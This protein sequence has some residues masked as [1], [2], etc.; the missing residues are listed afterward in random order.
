MWTAASLGIDPR[1]FAQDVDRTETNPVHGRQHVD[2]RQVDAH[3]D[4][5]DAR[6]ALEVRFIVRSLE[7]LV[8]PAQQRLLEARDLRG[9]AGDGRPSIRVSFDGVVEVVDDAGEVWR[10]QRMRFPQGGSRGFVEPDVGIDVFA[11]G[12]HSARRQPILS[13]GHG[14]RSRHS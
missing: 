10:H 14:A 2:L 11:K 5:A 7:E 4:P 13:G 3:V 12:L 1:R 9:A 8:D 6:P